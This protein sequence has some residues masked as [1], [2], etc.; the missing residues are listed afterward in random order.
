MLY[1]CHSHAINYCHHVPSLV[2]VTPYSTCDIWTASLFLPV[3]QGTQERL[4]SSKA[5]M[6]SK[7]GSSSDWLPGE[8]SSNRDS[9]KVSVC[10]GKHVSKISCQYRQRETN[11]KLFLKG[12]QLAYYQVLCRQNIRIQQNQMRHAKYIQPLFFCMVKVLHW[13]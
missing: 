7:A 1:I 9:S 11:A 3:M 6:R 8:R 4:G 13:Y 10:M 12:L 5:I 2:F